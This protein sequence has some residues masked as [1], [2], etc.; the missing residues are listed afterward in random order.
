MLELPQKM[1]S[2]KGTPVVAW[3]FRCFQQLRIQISTSGWIRSHSSGDRTHQRDGSCVFGCYVLIQRHNANV[4]HIWRF[5]EMEGTPSHHP[6]CFKDFPLQTIHFGAL[7]P[8]LWK[9][10]YNPRNVQRNSA[11]GFGIDLASSHRFPARAYA[12]ALALQGVSSSVDL[13]H[14]VVW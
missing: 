4:F 12:K 2:T 13:W 8:H 3:Y 9:P 11:W 5:P 14:C 6:L 10:P 7:Y 1:A